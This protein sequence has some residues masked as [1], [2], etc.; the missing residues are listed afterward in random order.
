VPGID[1]SEISTTPQAR[2]ERVAPPPA[3]TPSPSPSPSPSPQ[4]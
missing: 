2:P 3:I 4:A 1:A